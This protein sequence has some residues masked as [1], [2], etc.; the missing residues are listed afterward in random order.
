MSRSGSGGDVSDIDGDNINVVVRVRPLSQKENR[1][2]DEGIVQFP[3]EGQIW[4]RFLDHLFSIIIFHLLQ[5]DENKGALKPFTFNVV[6]EPE[7]TQEDV[8]EHSGMK[9]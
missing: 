5:V 4:V 2:H 1:N 6:F 3:G 9:R 8:L 7:A